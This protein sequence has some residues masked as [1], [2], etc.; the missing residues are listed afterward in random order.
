MPFIIFQHFKKSLL[1]AMSKLFV[2]ISIHNFHY[3]CCMDRTIIGLPKLFT[4]KTEIAHCITT[5]K[6]TSR[7]LSELLN[8]GYK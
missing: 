7:L 3:V 6:V 2:M 4:N 1:Y 8:E 5:L